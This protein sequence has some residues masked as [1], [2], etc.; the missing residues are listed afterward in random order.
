MNE[1]EHADGIP[2]L[3]TMEYLPSAFTSQKPVLR[4]AIRRTAVVGPPP[5]TA[6]IKMMT[7]I[8]LA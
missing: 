2:C 3:T 4:M 7:G 1:C 8:L 6:A 5:G